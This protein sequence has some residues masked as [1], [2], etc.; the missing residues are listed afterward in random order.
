MK[1]PRICRKG[2]KREA[3]IIPPRPTCHM[4]GNPVEPDQECARCDMPVC[5]NCM[6]F[7]DGMHVIEEIRCGECQEAIWDL[8]SQQMLEQ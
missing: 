1:I 8:R 4:C 5:E 7:G 2:N 3:P 6:V